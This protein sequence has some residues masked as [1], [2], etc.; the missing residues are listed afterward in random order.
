MEFSVTKCLNRGWYLEAFD[1]RPEAID[2][3]LGDRDDSRGAGGS[4]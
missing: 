1:D 4:E 2:W 3:L